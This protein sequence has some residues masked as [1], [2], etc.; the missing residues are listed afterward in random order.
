MRF[1]FGL[2]LGAV[3]TIAAAYYRDAT[4]ASAAVEIPARPLVNWDVAADVAGN[5]AA[6]NKR[7]INQLL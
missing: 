1:L 5:A 7:Q 6:A 2:F 3:L 4:Y